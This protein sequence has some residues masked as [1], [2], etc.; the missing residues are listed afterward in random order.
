MAGLS[1]PYPV[2]I[3][4][5]SDQQSPMVLGINDAR[6]NLANIGGQHVI[7]I[8]LSRTVQ[9]LLVSLDGVNYSS[10]VEIMSTYMEDSVEILTTGQ[11]WYTM[12][13]EFKVSASNPGLV[14]LDVVGDRNHA[15]WLIQLEVHQSDKVTVN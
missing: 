3:S 7:P 11:K 4:F 12:H 1:V 6:S 14:R 13:T 2:S 15:T 5:D 8:R 10:D 9:S